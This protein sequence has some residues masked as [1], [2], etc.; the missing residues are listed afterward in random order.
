MMGVELAKI[1][2]KY[3]KMIFFFE[4]LIDSDFFFFIFAL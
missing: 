4:E 1:H 3:G 2:D